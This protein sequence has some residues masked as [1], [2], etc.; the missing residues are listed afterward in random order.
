M[1]GEPKVTEVAVISGEPGGASV[2]TAPQRSDVD[3]PIVFSVTMEKVCHSEGVRL[4]AVYVVPA[5]GTAVPPSIL[6]K[7]PVIADPPVSAG[8]D[9]LAVIEVEVMVLKIRSEGE[10]G[11][12]ASV[13]SLSTKAVERMRSLMTK[14]ENSCDLPAAR[15]L[16]V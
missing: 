4:V 6:T 12:V 1:L 5:A 15:P 13:D 2:E 16:A 3:G 11:T 9:Q 7:Y 10:S 8:V 14:I